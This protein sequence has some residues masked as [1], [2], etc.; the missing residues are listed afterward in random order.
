MKPI[1]FNYERASSIEDAINLLSE[2]NVFVKIIA[3]SQSLGPMLNLR[4][5]QPELLIDITSI[6]E[7][8]DVASTQDYVDLGACIT[9]ADIEDGR[10]PDSSNGLLPHVA[11]S[12][13]YRA[14]RNRGT[15]GGSLAHGDPAADWISI[16]PLLDAE[17]IA[18]SRRGRRTIPAAEVLVSSFTTVLAQDELIETVRVPRLSDRARWGVYKVN[19]KAGEFAHAIASVLHDPEHGR[20]RA[21]IGAIET[22]P[23]V[24][25]DAAA[26]FSGSYGPNLAERMDQKL[27]GRMLDEHGV[28]DAYTLQ[29][30][31]TALKRAARGASAS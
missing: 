12:I 21:V 29:L 25:A 6:R 20:F 31:L 17:V 9:H 23:I 19:Q 8:T 13:A 5:A 15:I 16:F 3:G 1:D 28:R 2:Q 26:I 10:V 27:V 30:A 18:T 22:A 14:V 7:L 4:I 24:V 11:G